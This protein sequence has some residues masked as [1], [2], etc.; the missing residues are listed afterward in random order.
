MDKDLADNVCLWSE[1]SL[2]LFCPLGRYI[3]D[4]H[5]TLLFLQLSRLGPRLNIKMLSYQ[6][7]KSH[8]G[9]KTVVRSSY[10]HNGISYTGKMTS[11]YWIKALLITNVYGV[12]YT[13][14][15]NWWLD[16]PKSI[17]SQKTRIGTNNN[18]ASIELC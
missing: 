8:C 3:Y 4:Y 13:T 17:F 6:Y 10:L 9:D 16:I 1:L 7:R 11:L 18:I 14:G 12:L 15:L 2:Q 5:Y